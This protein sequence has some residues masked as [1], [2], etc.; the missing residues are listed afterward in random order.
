M[1]LP[2]YD[3]SNVSNLE[4]YKGERHLYF[5]HVIGH[6]FIY[7]ISHDACILLLH[8]IAEASASD[9]LFATYLYSSHASEPCLCLIWRPRDFVAPTK[10]DIIV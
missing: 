8:I 9:M 10:R 3:G 1:R 4:N 5:L 6:A 2:I 7:K